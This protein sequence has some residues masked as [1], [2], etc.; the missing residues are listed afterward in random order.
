MFLRIVEF[1]VVALFVLIIVTQ[2]ILPPL[3]GKRFFWFFK[4]TE[5]NLRGKQSELMDA[6]T[7]KETRKV[8]REVARVSKGK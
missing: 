2:I 3:I 1:G 4:K 6:R 8:E 5:K 7:E